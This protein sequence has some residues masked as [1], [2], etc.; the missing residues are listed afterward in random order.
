MRGKREYAGV[1]ERA[2]IRAIKTGRQ[3]ISG[4]IQ[5]AGM[6]EIE[7]QEA[8]DYHFPSS[9]NFPRLQVGVSPMETK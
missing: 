5:R 3:Q 6:F 9:S 7:I 4:D 2:A 1:L 8:C